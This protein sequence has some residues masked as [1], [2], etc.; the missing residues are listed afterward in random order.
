MEILRKELLKVPMDMHD[1]YNNLE[2]IYFSFLN[3]MFNI[4]SKYDPQL[5]DICET[6]I[7]T[8]IYYYA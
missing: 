1:P 5:L 7:I 3:A 8:N 4:L 2:D 6:V